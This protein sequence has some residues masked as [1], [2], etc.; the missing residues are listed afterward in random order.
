MTVSTYYATYV[1]G[2]SSMATTIQAVF[3]VA[4]VIAVFIV[5]PVDRKLGRR[6]TMMTGALVFIAAMILY[7]ILR[8]DPLISVM[9][10]AVGAGIS[11]TFTYILFN[12]N[13]NEICDLI[14]HQSGKRIDSMIASA[15]GLIQKLA[16]AVAVQFI[17]FVLHYAGFNEALPNQPAT[18]PAAIENLISWAPGVLALCMTIVAFFHPIER[19]HREMLAQKQGNER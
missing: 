11:I 7:L 9:V 3:L 18:V 2:S 4:N 13:R 10:V 14:Q 19:E 12:T 6:K 1:L 15:D 8:S 17:A 16:S 5:G